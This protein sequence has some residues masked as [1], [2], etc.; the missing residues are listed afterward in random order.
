[1]YG[2]FR[3]NFHHFDRLELDLRGHTRARGA[4]LSCPRFRLAD[5]VLMQRFYAVFPSSGV[6]ERVFKE[7]EEL[8]LAFRALDLDGDGMITKAEL[9]QQLGGA[10]DDSQLDRIIAEADF[11]HDG[12]ISKEEFIRA[13]K[14]ERV[15]DTPA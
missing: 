4:A 15:E 13:M 8:M 5:V 10:F 11:S 14:G 2:T 9:R 3:L 7:E 6:E 1:M 12:E